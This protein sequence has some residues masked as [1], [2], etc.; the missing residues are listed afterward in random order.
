MHGSI[1]NLPSKLKK[2]EVGCKW[3]TLFKDFIWGSVMEEIQE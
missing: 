2:E 1:G 3:A